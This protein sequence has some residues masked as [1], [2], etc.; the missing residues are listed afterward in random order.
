M[1]GH[2]PM[3]NHPVSTSAFAFSGNAFSSNARIFCP[4]PGPEPLSLSAA[5]SHV[6]PDELAE[7]LDSGDEEDKKLVKKR[8]KLEKEAKMS[9]DAAHLSLSL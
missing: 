3:V 2:A 9:I 4:L 6:P 7:Q 8:S 5:L 1:L